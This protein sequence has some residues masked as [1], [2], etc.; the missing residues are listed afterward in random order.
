MEEVA[1]DILMLEQEAE[2]LIADI[3]GVDV[4]VVSGV[5]HD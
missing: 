3:L 5:G 4:A 1:K 2:G